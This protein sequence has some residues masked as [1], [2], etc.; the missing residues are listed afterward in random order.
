MLLPNDI[1]IYETANGPTVW[2]SQRLVVEHCEVGE[3]HLRTH[4]RDR[5]KS[6]LPASWQ[7]KTEASEFLLDHKPGKS[8]RWGR[9][10][11][12]YYYDV[13]TIPNREPT[14]YRDR[15]PSKDELIAQVQ[16]NR[17]RGSRER[18][19][20]QRRN[21]V[22]QALLLV[23]DG[24][25]GDRPVARH[26]CRYGRDGAGDGQRHAAARMEGSAMKVGG[27]SGQNTGE[28]LYLR[29]L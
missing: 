26:P 28:R 7:K 17:L 5:Y 3:D 15:L 9:K 14:C 2:V 29:K 11:G 6:S 1:L 19:A 18:Q 27:T 23:D 25:G 22:E 10:N 21:L 12:Q 13:D 8:W 16:A 20:E 24:S 4:C